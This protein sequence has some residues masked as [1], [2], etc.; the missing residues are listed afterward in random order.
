MCKEMKLKIREKLFSRGFGITSE[1][2]FAREEKMEAIL[3]SVLFLIRKLLVRL[4]Y[5]R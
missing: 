1:Y 3:F 2:G 5:N 4:L